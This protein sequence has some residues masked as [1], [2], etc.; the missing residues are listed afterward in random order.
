MSFFKMQEHSLYHKVYY[1]SDTPASA[2]MVCPRVD[3]W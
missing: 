1:F 2:T 3:S